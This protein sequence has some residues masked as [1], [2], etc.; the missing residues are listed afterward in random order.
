MNVKKA[1]PISGSFFPINAK[2][3]AKIREES[4]FHGLQS[5]KVSYIIPE[6]LSLDLEVSSAM[7]TKRLIGGL[8]FFSVFLALADGLSIAALA[9]EPASETVRV[10]YYEEDSRFQNGFSAE[11]RKTGYAYEYY[12]EIAV[13]TGWSYEYIYGTKSELI[14]M[15]LSGEVD[16]VAGVDKTAA[17]EEQ[18]LF[19]EHD[20]GLPDNPSYF[21]VNINRPDLLEGLDDAINKIL[22]SNPGFTVS[23][24]QKYY[25]QTSQVQSL[26]DEERDYLSEIGSLR[27]GYVSSNLPLS[28]I[29]EDGQPTG[30]ISVLLS[31]LSSYLDLPL[32]P[33]CFETG[34]DMED[35]LR[36]GEIDAAFP[37]YSDLWTTETKGLFQTS[38]VLSDRV[39]IVYRGS[40]TAGLLDKTA[41]SD[42]GLGQRYYLATYHPD[43]EQLFYET[44]EDAFQA[45]M[46]GEA[47]YMVGCA[48]IIQRFLAEHPKY[49]GFNIAYLDVSEEFSIAVSRS[50]HMLVEI[51]DKAVIQ[52][53]S[54]TIT[55]ALVQY[56]YVEPTYT[57]VDFIQRHVV[58]VVAVLA[59]FLAILLWVFI[60]YFRKTK[61][62]NAEQVKAQAAL[63]EALNAANAANRAKT[64][65][66][67]SMSHDLRTPMNGVIGMT[68]IA[69]AHI[70]DKARV[71]DCLTK[72]TSS[73]KHL[74]GLI[75][76]VLDMSKI[77]SGSVDLNEERMDLSEL[78]DSL[79]SLNETQANARKQDLE[80]HILNVTHEQVI[81]DSLRLQQVFTNLVSNAIKYT[82][83][84]GRIEI[85]LSEKPSGSPKLAC[86]E[87]S[88][89][90]N[91]IG[92]SEEFL[93]HV[94]DAFSRADES[95]KNTTQGTGLGMTIARSVIRMMGGDITVESTLGKGSKFT[96]TIFLKLP[97]TEGISYEDFIDLNILVVDDDQVVCESA[98]LLL[99]DLGMKGE[100]LLSGQEAVERVDQRHQEGNDYFAV[101]LDWKMEGMDGIET[102]KE[103]RKRVG[104]D[105]P[106]IVISAYDWSTIEADALKA[107]VNAFVGKPLF[108]SRLVHLFNDLM[109]RNNEKSVSGLRNLIEES[110][111][112]GK[113][114]LLAEDNELN[115]EIAIEILG[116]IGLETEWAHD[117]REAV[118]MMEKSAPGYYDCIFMDVQMPVMGG[119]DAAKAI[120][121]LPNADAKTIPIFA[122]TANVFTDDVVAAMNA[123]M[124]EHIA[125]PL[126]MDNLIMVLNKYLK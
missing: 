53:D 102:T 15:L 44:R 9:A 85:T 30:V 39:M 52:L 70:N 17:H 61:R 47:N 118:N 112:S 93:P 8:L 37:V 122:M 106:I 92:I 121:I 120:R 63:E 10:G 4:Q 104:N 14:D 99:D 77:E 64:L 46:D 75:N 69:A 35:A 84:G 109:G 78:M 58:M 87:F 83:E 110:D 72:I 29:G 89:K 81:G 45:I 49:E 98:C 108:K 59:S 51:L 60:A 80:V 42:T 65:F 12:Q 111:F 23:L 16:I 11:E 5:L 96:A 2:H 116:M 50:N 125:K 7:K 86:Y 113:R 27:F 115:A 22:N 21:A 56:S 43:T 62:F 3:Y 1:A 55:S 67:S 33:V 26:T 101:L 19:S 34:R 94:F 68:A 57:I 24:Y 36:S 13:L 105:V 74:L 66:L 123:G 48:S 114:A 18:M 91:G 88:V 6:R 71:E 32:V 103:I 54:A 107:G 90:D 97:D 40:Y 100:W 20:M 126:D 31:H 28:D 41:L 76:E 79:I 95:S 119:L 25:G 82:Q 124:N 73:S 117:G 38:P